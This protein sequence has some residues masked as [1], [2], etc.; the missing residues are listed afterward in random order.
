M[1]IGVA[2]GQQRRLQLKQKYEEI[3]DEK[4]IDK[5]KVVIKSETSK[6]TIEQVISTIMKE[7]RLDHQDASIIRDIHYKF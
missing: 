7:L 5:N 1:Q 2:N 4:T 6:M 3:K